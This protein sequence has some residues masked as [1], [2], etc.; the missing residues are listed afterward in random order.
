MAKLGMTA[1]IPH[2]KKAALMPRKV[3]LFHILNLGNSAIGQHYR[4]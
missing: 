3:N 1:H 2:L 4:L